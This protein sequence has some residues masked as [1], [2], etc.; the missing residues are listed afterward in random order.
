MSAAPAETLPT[1][2]H[3]HGLCRCGRGQNGVVQ[4]C[5]AN[6]CTNELARMARVEDR[7]EPVLGTLVRLQAF[8]IAEASQGNAFAGIFCASLAK[9][10]AVYAQFKLF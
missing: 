2:L 8:S 1:S 4:T 5:G 9:C 3:H 6:R 7:R 10:G